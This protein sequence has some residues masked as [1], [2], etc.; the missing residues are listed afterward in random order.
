MTSDTL[1]I[2]TAVLIV[3]IIISIISIYRTKYSK[4]GNIASPEELCKG[5]K[6][7]N[8][9]EDIKCIQNKDNQ[10]AGHPANRGCHGSNI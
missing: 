9:I 8:C 5:S 1:F 4:F 2:I 6:M 3:L 10:Y 7:D